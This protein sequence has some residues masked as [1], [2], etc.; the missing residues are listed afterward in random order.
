VRDERAALVKGYSSLSP[1]N[2]LQPIVTIADLDHDRTL[3]SAWVSARF[4]A[5]E[6]ADCVMP[7]HMPAALMLP[8]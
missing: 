3:F 1:L 5:C 6:T 4:M 2:W 8:S 7:S